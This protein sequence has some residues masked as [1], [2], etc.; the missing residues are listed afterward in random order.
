MIT[1]TY[2]EPLFHSF[3]VESNSGVPG[4]RI[5]AP[6]SG[7]LFGDKIPVALK[8]KNVKNYSAN[9]LGV[10]DRTLFKSCDFQKLVFVSKMA[11]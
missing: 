9:G 4:F 8:S 11:K 6:D 10:L 5:C 2:P 3:S 1:T 7:F